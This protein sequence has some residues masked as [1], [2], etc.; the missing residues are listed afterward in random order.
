MAKITHETIKGL[1][2]GDLAWDDDVRGFYARCQA[3]EKKY[4]LKTRFRGRPV[5]LT[6]GDCG[7]WTP[8]QARTEASRLK[9]ELRAGVDPDKLRASVRGQPII[10]D[11]C[12]RYIAEHIDVHLKASTAVTFKRLLKVHIKTAWGKRLVTDV[13]SDDV[14]K[15][16]HKLRGTPRTAN[17]TVAVASKMFSLAE[18]WKLRPL[19]S[20]PCRHLQK[21]KEAVRSRFYDDAELRAIGEAVASLD[22][23][24]AIL[25][26]AAT[27]IRLAPL[28]GCRLGELLNLKWTDV[29]LQAGA[30]E[31]RDAKAGGRRHPIGAA[32][33]AFLGSLTRVG[34]WVCQ[35]IV[36]DQRLSTRATQK[37]WEDVRE[38][39]GLADARFHDLRHSYGTFAGATGV[40]AFLVRDAMG[41]KTLAM[42]GRYVTQ[43]VDPMRQ[44]VDRVAGRV[45]G[46]MSGKDA[47]VL[48][49]PANRS[50]AP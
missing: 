13:S 16:H 5:W 15:L 25:P 17:Q 2:P 39:A 9:R 1:Q 4:G 27:A 24:G 30:L 32:A 49:V 29:D 41:H 33:V 48:P 26:G 14:A 35:G 8:T 19:N 12:D 44:L 10:D 3:K 18:L 21:F 45:A 34:P 6:I 46:A 11:L 23:E 37:A 47:E 38:R 20:N 40:N 43:D 22:A 28:T 31:I 42:T 36:P 7:S 50:A